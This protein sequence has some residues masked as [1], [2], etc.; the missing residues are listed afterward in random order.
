[1]KKTLLFLGLILFVAFLQAQ[2]S[3]LAN[4]YLSQEI[5]DGYTMEESESLFPAANCA[6]PQTLSA[7]YADDCKSVLLK[8]YAP[9]EV[10]FAQTCPPDAE[11]FH[12]GYRST[13]WMMEALQRDILADDFDVP[14]GE[15]WLIT[16][17]YLY[18]FINKETGE[19][20]N[21]VGVEIYENDGGMPG[22][23]LLEDPFLIPKSGKV[24][25]QNTVILSTPLV[26]TGPA[27]Y[28]LAY[29]GVYDDLFESSRVFFS[30]LC[31]NEYGEQLVSF[32]D[33]V[34]F[35][36][37]FDPPGYHSMYFNVR[38]T[39]S[40]DP[41]RYNLYRDNEIIAP[42][43]LETTFTDLDADP[44]VRHT[45]AVTAA[46]PDGSESNRITAIQLQCAGID[47]NIATFTILPNPANDL[48]K[49]TSKSIINKLEII[50][51]LGQTVINQPNVGTAETTLDVSLLHNGVYFV[52][53][54]T[55]NGSI[56]QKFVKQ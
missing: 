30:C 42:N 39:K 26:V 48:I 1:M 54:T 15:T 52:R 2:N 22:N 33:E 3:K 35:W 27:K 32:D 14:A 43:I 25:G 36:E 56:V 51:F 13:R 55:D 41:V 45:W 12:H 50:N 47:E 19:E 40:L 8:W 46:C 16:E 17:I 4:V 20:P 44:T 18:G 6:T 28:W 23:Q 9:A 49:I 53:I 29:Y 37:T 38:G 10:L 11:G 5:S 34:G 31:E 24:T 21:F 7:K